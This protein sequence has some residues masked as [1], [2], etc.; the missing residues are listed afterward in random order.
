MVCRFS[1]GTILYTANQIHYVPA[2]AGCKTVPQPAF[3]MYTESGGVVAM[4]EGTW[5]IERVVLPREL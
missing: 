5:T 1:K 4:M 2:T 3:Q